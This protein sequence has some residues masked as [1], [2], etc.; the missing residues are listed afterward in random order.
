MAAGLARLSGLHL[1]KDQEMTHTQAE[2]AFER[3]NTK[4][5]FHRLHFVETILFVLFILLNEVMYTMN[6]M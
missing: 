4:L 2:L 5:Q 6:E 3:P 1:Q